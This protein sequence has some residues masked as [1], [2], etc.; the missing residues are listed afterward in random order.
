MEMS[1]A[2]NHHIYIVSY[3]GFGHVVQGIRK[4]AVI[5]EYNPAKPAIV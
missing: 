4:Q 2:I 3:G 1:A 5:K